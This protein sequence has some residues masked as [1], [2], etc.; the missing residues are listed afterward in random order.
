MKILGKDYLLNAGFDLSQEGWRLEQ[1]EE[2]GFI[3]SSS[4]FWKFALLGFEVNGIFLV[5]FNLGVVVNGL[6]KAY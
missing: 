6:Y 3:S 5:G 2:L 1:V 4:I